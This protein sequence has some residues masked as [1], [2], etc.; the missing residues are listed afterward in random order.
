M[1]KEMSEVQVRP[2]RIFA[3]TLYFWKLD[4]RPYILPLTVM[5]YFNQ[6]FL[7]AP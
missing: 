4:S 1:L 6:I 5:V 7:W 3:K 2:L